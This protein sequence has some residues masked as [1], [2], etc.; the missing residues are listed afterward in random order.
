VTDPNSVAGWRSGCNPTLPL[1]SEGGGGVSRI[2]SHLERKS[3][4]PVPTL[5]FKQ[6]FS[7]L[8]PI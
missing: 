2:D 8:A 7:Q 4:P 6:V 5:T 1:T 3:R